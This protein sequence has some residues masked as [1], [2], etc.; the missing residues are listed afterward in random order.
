MNHIEL[1][2]V[3]PEE[4]E[5]R[6]FELI[7]EELGD[8]PLIPGTEAIVKRCIHTS[9]D[10]DYAQNLV[11]TENAVER[12]LNALKNGASIV[13]DTQMGKAGIS[14]KTLAQYGGEVYCFMS[15][16]DVAQTAKE[17]GTT[18]AAASMDKAAALDKNLIFAVGNAPT[19]LVRLYELVQE[20]KLK[21]ELIIA[22]PVGFVNVV[23]SK[24]LILDLE[25]IP[26]IVAKGR[27]G[28]SNIA[29]CICNALL[30]ML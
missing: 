20:G 1:E 28:G 2:K 4:I 25:E 6:S 18:R 3:L 15:D 30:Y 5:A 19:A 22:V 8:T 13:T 23:Q 7:T 9:A 27:K 26:S 24:E 12:A 17:Q 21:P 16:E 11:F 10:F 14:K 29:A